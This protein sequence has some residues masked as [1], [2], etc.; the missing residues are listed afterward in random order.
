M[1]T[2]T[3]EP[4]DWRSSVTLTVLASQVDAVLDG[5]EPFLDEDDIVVDGGNHLPEVHRSEHRSA[6]ED[7]KGRVDRVTEAA[8]RWLAARTTRPSGRCRIE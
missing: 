7:R 8:G 4:D 3:A 6:A 1:A 5:L 2:A